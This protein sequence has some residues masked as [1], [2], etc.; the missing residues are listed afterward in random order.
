M[1]AYFGLGHVRRVERILAGDFGER[2]TL[3]RVKDRV[4][5]VIVSCLA[6]LIYHEKDKLG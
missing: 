3:A 4:K 1:P 2:Q 5:S 6:K